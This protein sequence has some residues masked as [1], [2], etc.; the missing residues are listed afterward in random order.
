MN[1]QD[2]LNMKCKRIVVSIGDS[3]DCNVIEPTKGYELDTKG[4]NGWACPGFELK[5]A[6]AICKEL[7]IDYFERT[8]YE[9][10]EKYNT[11]LFKNSDGEVEVWQG[12]EHCTVDGVKTLFAVGA[13]SWTWNLLKRDE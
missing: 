11:I 7:S 13:W 8:T 6:L 3:P 10:N 9:Y 12:Q 4:W 2:A 5:E 1:I